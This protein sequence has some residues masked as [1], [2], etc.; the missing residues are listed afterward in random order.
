MTALDESPVNRAGSRSKFG[1]QMI[2]KLCKPINVAFSVEH[3]RFAATDIS[4]ELGSKPEHEHYAALPPDWASHLEVSC[5][6]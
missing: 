4:N 5:S 6:S 1:L 2:K 3:C